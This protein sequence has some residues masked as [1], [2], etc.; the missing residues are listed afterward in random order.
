[1]S[2]NITS[3]DIIKYVSRVLNVDI[4]NSLVMQ[5][6]IEDLTSIH[7]LG[8]FRFFIKE[9]FN[10]S[11]YQYLT[12]YQKF[13][14]LVKDFKKQNAPR[15]NSQQK[16]KVEDYSERLFK[17]TVDVFDWVNWEIQIG[18]DLYC[19]EI[20]KRLFDEFG[21]E[22]KDLKVLE[23]IGKRPELVRLVRYHKEVLR[24]KIQKI[25]FKLTLEKEYPQLTHKSKEQ[26]VLERLGA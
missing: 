5:D 10:E 1:M 25:V 6:M 8:L 7:D 9:N 4:T 15:L 21:N 24:E 23:M 17:K 18:K 3:N 22:P 26:L 20:S 2:A 14:A 19:K 13:L 12:G 11:K 16:S